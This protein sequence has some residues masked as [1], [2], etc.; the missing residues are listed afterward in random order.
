MI[1]SWTN[2]QKLPEPPS[3]P[4]LDEQLPVSTASSLHFI[5]DGKALIVSYSDHGIV[6]ETL[7]VLY[8]SLT[9]VASVVGTSVRWN[10]SGTSRRE[11]AA[12]TFISQTSY[13]YTIAQPL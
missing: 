3:P 8:L 10:R 2:A 6:Y 11:H 12:C 13:R 1:A 4:G 9:C 5:D 7:L